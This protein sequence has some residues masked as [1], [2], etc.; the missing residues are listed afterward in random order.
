VQTF[1]ILM[2]EL[3]L[4]HSIRIRQHDKTAK[5][6]KQQLVFPQEAKNT[7]D[8]SCRRP[9]IA[10]ALAVAQSRNTAFST[11]LTPLDP[12]FQRGDDK[13]RMHK[14]RFYPPNKGNNGT[15][16]KNER[17]F[18]RHSRESGNPGISAAIRQTGF[19]FARE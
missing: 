1:R 4:T 17:S 19:P 3:F 7:F 2:F 12:V 13:L 14:K 10:V 15:C 18:F 16:G 5:S 11:G 9:R 8:P 6:L